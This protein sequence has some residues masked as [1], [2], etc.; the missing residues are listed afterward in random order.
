MPAPPRP[1]AGSPARVRDSVR[2]EC[3]YASLAEFEAN[4]GIC[5]V[6]HQDGVQLVGKEHEQI[7]IGGFPMSPLLGREVLI[8]PRPSV[9]T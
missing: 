1:G 6:Q 3:A 7:L 2:A 4:V 5:E 9:R 8:C